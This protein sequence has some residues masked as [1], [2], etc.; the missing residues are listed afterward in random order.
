M[1]ASNHSEELPRRL[2]TIVPGTTMCTTSATPRSSQTRYF[3]PIA[4]TGEVPWW[5]PPCALSAL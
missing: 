2:P 4:D 1:A 5:R 3:P